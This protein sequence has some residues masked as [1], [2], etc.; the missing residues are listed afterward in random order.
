MSTAAGTA[1]GHDAQDTRRRPWLTVLQVVLVV[2][3]LGWL[4]HLFGT[5]AVTAAG[6]VLTPWSLCVALVLGIV[7]GIVQGLRWKVVAGGLGDHIGS[8]HAIARCLE[9]AFLNAVLPGGLA[10]DAVRAVRRRRAGTRWAVGIGS[11]VGERLCGTAVVVTAAVLAAVAFGRL[12]L[13]GVLAAALVVILGV[14]GWSMRRLPPGRIAACVL[15]SVVGWLCYLGLFVLAVGGL[16]RAEATP[17]PT[18]G[19]GTGL[20]T[21]LALGSITLGGMSVPLNV[22]GWGPREGAAVFAYDL[23]G[24][25]GAAGFTTSVAYGLLALVSVTPGLLVLLSGGRVPYTR[26]RRG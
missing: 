6:A 19:T 13:A 11:V 20:E 12:D 24:L 3:L 22:G 1:P 16:A 5:Q 25:G 8:R 26:R 18:L 9:A 14:A 17:Q 15:W 10:G 2:A 23:A 4:V 7:G 21:A